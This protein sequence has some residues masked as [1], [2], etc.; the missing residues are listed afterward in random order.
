VIAFALILAGFGLLLSGLFSGS[1]TALY[2]VARLRLELA[3]ATGDR[4][5]A[6][7]GWLAARTWLY[8]GTVLTGN[9]V[10]NYV[11]SMGVVLLIQNAADLRGADAET[12]AALLA[13][14]LLFLCGELL[15]KR[16]GLAAPFAT[17]RRCGPLLVFF[18]L[19]FL[20]ISLLLY[21]WDRLWKA[22]LSKGPEDVRSFITDRELRRILD[23]AREAGLLFDM[24]RELAS[25]IFAASSQRITACMRPLSHF[26][27]VPWNAE[28]AELEAAIRQDPPFAL[29]QDP[30]RKRLPAGYVDAVSILLR[31]GQ[32]G[33]LERRPLLRVP[34][35]ETVVEVLTQLDERGEPLTLVQDRDGA[36]M[37]VVLKSD[38]RRMLLSDDLHPREKPADAASLT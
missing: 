28:L 8:I 26:P 24:Q 19:L 32:S 1:E 25:R 35:D 18:A 16:L 11:F 36:P 9:N 12:A 7:V 5:M 22:F 4:V 20:P 2:R 15:P 17:L 21:L 30:N 29:L 27:V 31:R 38:L 3:A 34:A 14:P 37:G 10:A 33:R 23:E 13:A 6:A